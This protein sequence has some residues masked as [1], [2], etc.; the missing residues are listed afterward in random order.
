MISIE[1]KKQEVQLSSK[2][3]V[4]Q[5]ELGLIIDSTHTRKLMRKNNL[6]N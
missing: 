6:D 3:K 5:V 1:S 4:Q 2:Q